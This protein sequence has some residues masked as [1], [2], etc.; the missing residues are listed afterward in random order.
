[1]RTV[2]WE[3]GKVILINQ[4]KLPEEVVYVE[5]EDY[6][7]VAESIKTL[8]IRGAPAIGVAAAMA[9]ALAAYQS[10][11]TS[12]HA[13]RKDLTEAAEVIKATRPT[14][15]NLFWAVER[16]LLK[17]ESFEGDVSEAVEG[18][19][20]EAVLMAE[21][22]VAANKAMGTH[23]AMLLE[24]GDVVGTICNAGRLATAGEY[25]TALGVIKVAHEQGK[26]ISV[27]ALETRPVLQ[28]ARL[29]AFELMQ[30]GIDVKVVCDGAV[31]Y[32]FYKGMIDKFICGADRIVVADDCYV[33]NKVGTHTVSLVA[34]QYGVPFYV[35]APLSTFDFQHRLGEVEIEERDSREVTNI[36]KRRIVPHGV[37]VLNPAFDIT[38][39]EFVNAIITE[40][41]VIQPPFK[42]NLKHVVP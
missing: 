18:I 36:G 6:H 20:T 14:A 19:V 10:N 23:G 22:D 35:A 8:E 13:L 39:P 24:D 37:S 28:G 25:G 21:E 11:A 7:R 29:T 41:G 4:K 34:K 26:K 12:R 30:D 3:K 17:A 31:G 2:W 33:I 40:K 9:L 1:M 38:P 42:T 32:L 27:I 5:C 16:V 15:R